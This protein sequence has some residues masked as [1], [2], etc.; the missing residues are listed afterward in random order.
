MPAQS[1]AGRMCALSESSQIDERVYA[2]VT[3]VGNWRLEQAWRSLPRAD[4]HLLKFVEGGR[5]GSEL[6]TRAV[7]GAVRSS[8]VILNVTFRPRHKLLQFF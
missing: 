1:I 8:L 5:I 7:D 4:Q 2:E 6:C 3:P